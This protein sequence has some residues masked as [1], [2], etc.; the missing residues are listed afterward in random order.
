[1]SIARAIKGTISQTPRQD[2]ASPVRKYLTRGL[3]RILP[4]SVAVLLFPTP[5]LIYICCGLADLLRNKSVNRAMLVRY[6]T[7]N[8][9]FTWLLSPF[10]LFMDLLTLPYWN[11]GVYDL[12]DLPKPYQDEINSVIDAATKSNVVEELGKRLGD[13]KRGMFFFKWY[14]KN[15]RGSVDFPAFHQPY[16]YICT[17]GVSVFNKKQSTGEHFGPLR[18]TLRVLYNLTKNDDP[19]VYIKVGDRKHQWKTNKLFIFDDTLQH[20]SCNESNAVRYCM[21]V[22]ILRPSPV[23]ELLR[24]ILSV[25]RLISLRFNQAFYKN[26]TFIK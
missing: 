9:I 1:M 16:K 15:L 4:I 5:L 19:N 3:K 11:R 21:F 23:P 12:A 17:I 22:D 10:N 2:R 18:I 14:G 13:E 6:F 26:W 25:V 8:G 24:I 20:Q 7:G